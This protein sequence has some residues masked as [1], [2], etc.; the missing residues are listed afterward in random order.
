MKMSTEL[1]EAMK[2]RTEVIG[3]E[4]MTE[5]QLRGACKDR[6]RNFAID[7]NNVLTVMKEKNPVR[8]F[9]QQ[10]TLLTNENRLN[11]EKLQG[12]TVEDAGKVLV[13]YFNDP[14]VIQNQK[15]LLKMAVDPK[16][17]PSPSQFKQFTNSL[18]VRIQIK[19]SKRQEIV[20]KM[21]RGESK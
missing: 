17:I 19:N 10:K 1:K 5:D 11:K 13:K 8:M 16:A 4:K 2:F 12:Q 14:D 7:C 18:L 6:A 20:T 9:S 21:T 3:S 15:E